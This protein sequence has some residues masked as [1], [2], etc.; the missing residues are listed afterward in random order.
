MDHIA[1]DAVTILIV[2][3]ATYAGLCAC[4]IGSSVVVI[5]GW[6]AYHLCADRL[7]APIDCLKASFHH[8]K[9]NMGEIFIFMLVAG[10]MQTLVIVLTCGLGFLLTTPM[11]FIAWERFYA[12]NRDD[13]IAAADAAGVPR[14]V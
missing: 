14:L 7:Y 2:T 13:I 1:D 12:A 9:S 3:V 6:W 4:V 8:A 10:L 11:Y 5:L